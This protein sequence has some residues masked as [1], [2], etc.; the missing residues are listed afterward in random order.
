MQA[1]LLLEAFDVGVHAFDLLILDLSA[2]PRLAVT[3]RPRIFRCP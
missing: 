2:L 1:L 3:D